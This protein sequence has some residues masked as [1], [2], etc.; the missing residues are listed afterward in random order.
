MGAFADQMGG[1]AGLLRRVQAPAQAGIFSGQ[2]PS[3]YNA[4]DP[5]RLWVIQIVIIILLTQLLSLVLSRMRQPRVIAEVIGGVILGPSVMGHI[6]RFTSTIFPSQS[7]PLLTLTANIGLVLFLF[8]VGL[9]VDFRII[10]RNA[11]ASMAISA[12]GLIIPLGLGAALGVPIYHVFTNE[13]VSFGHFLLFVAVAIGITAFP[14]LC[15]ILTELKLLDTT[16][17][18]VTLAAGVGNDVVGWI[19]L[20]LSVALVNSGSGIT[21]L[22]VL[23]AA[24]GYVLFLTI[25]VRWALRWLAR[26]TGCLETGQPT[27]MLMTIIILLVFISAFYT[28][29]IGIHAIF[30]GFLAGLIIPKDNGFAI[31]VVEKLEDLVS[32]LFVPLYFA[33]SGLNTNLG[34]LDNGITWAYVVLICVVAFFSKFVGCAIA[35]KITG[36]SLRESSA[37]GVLMSCKGLVELIVLNVGLDAGILD[38]RT[39]SMFVLHALVLT[40]MTTPLTILLYPSKYRKHAGSA[41]DKEGAPGVSGGNIRS[42]SLEQTLKSKFMV[43]LDKIEQVPSIMT[44]TQLLQ[45]PPTASS[46]ISISDK[47]STSQKEDVSAGMPSAL[48]VIAPT[49][50]GHSSVTALRLIELTDRTSAVLKSQHADSL[51]GSDHILSIFRTFGYLNRMAV[52][53]ALSVVGHEEFPSTVASHASKDSAQLVIVPWSRSASG[54]DDGNGLLS[55]ASNL[56]AGLFPQLQCSPV[57]TSQ[58]IRK[59]FAETPTDVALFVDQNA[60]P[61]YGVQGGQHLFLPFFGGPDDRLALSFVAQL[62][63]NPSVTATVIRIHKS[64]T[65]DL[66][67]VNTIDSTEKMK[68]SSPGFTTVHHDTVYNLLDVQAHAASEEA[69]NTMWA[70]YALPPTD[71]G[72]AFARMT[73]KDEESSQPLHTALAGVTDAIAHSRLTR[74]RVLV[75]TGRSR[76]MNY[77]AWRDAFHTELLELCKERGTS[78]S[79]DVQKTLGDVAAAFVAA[80]SNVNLLVMQACVGR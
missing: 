61:L 73:F 29:V 75:V 80:N 66:T 24:V 3:D 20:A 40:F 70:Q 68:S 28:D 13:D 49:Q 22:W 4:S 42:M 79:S 37:I 5:I 16:V 6:P 17:G 54:D 72:S 8:L 33:S 25:P 62:C 48:P 34:L 38:T 64:S 7:I 26:R 14:V 12:V 27:G 78:L 50:L 71:D 2:N 41:L 36:F 43:V 44:L 11:R 63:L 52:Q 15:R 74:S 47:L 39:F 21:A 60:P 65:S 1:A 19:L 32:I 53:C 23:L 10:R 30:G 67:A 69:D 55:S 56:S 51:I 76:S 77:D 31:A 45:G 18:V 57:A 58:Y 59:V 9:E 46:S 35:A